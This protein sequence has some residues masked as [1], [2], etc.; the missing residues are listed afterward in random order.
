MSALGDHET[1]LQARVQPAEGRCVVTLSGELDGLAGPALAQWLHTVVTGTDARYVLIDMAQVE[2]LDVAGL[3]VLRDAHQL[4]TDRGIVFNVRDPQPHIR[5]LLHQTETADRLLA[6][7]TGD[8]TAAAA[9]DTRQPS[10][11][12]TT[13]V[14]TQPVSPVDEVAAT[15]N[16]HANDERDRRADDRELLDVE[17]ARLLDER[18]AQ[19]QEHERWEDIREDQ[20]NTREQRLNRRDHGR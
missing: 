18:S 16:D 4:A 13:S 11:S 9:L 10:T 2:F 15:E 6:D 3:R 14:P 7:T 20:A 1:R 17:R 12:S 19:V 8:V 5:W